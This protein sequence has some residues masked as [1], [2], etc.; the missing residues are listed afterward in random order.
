MILKPEHKTF[1]DQYKIKKCVL[2]N[3]VSDTDV[4]TI[5]F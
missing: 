3:L 4:Y 1:K 2:K 5:G